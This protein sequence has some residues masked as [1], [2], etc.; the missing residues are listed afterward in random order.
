MTNAFY[1]AI[2]LFLLCIGLPSCDETEVQDPKK[3]IDEHILRAQLERVQKPSIT[4]EQDVIDSYIKQ[5][6]LR[7]Q[8]TG[9]GLRFQ[10]IIEKPNGKKIQSLDEITIKYNVF[11]LDGTLCYSSNQKGPR[12]L[13]VDFDNI[14]TGLHEGLKLMRVGEKYLFILPSHLAHGLTG[15]QDKI[16]PKSSVLF[17]IEVLENTKN[18]NLS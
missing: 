15:D 8:T 4:M 16:P 10:K 9:T 1:S 2:L 12:K 3:Q 5:H 18:S 11:L 13:K 6:Q 7:M 14:E 17:E